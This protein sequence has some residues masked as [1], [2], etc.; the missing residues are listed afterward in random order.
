[1]AQPNFLVV[2][3]AL[4]TLGAA[5]SG[6]GMN[7]LR[8][9][10]LYE[11]DEPWYQRKRLLAGLALA[12]L[13][14]TGVDW[15]ALAF[16]PLSIVAPLG[17]VTI[18]V[19]ALLARAGVLVPRELIR[20]EQW[21]AIVVTIVGVVLV[22][23]YGPHNEPDLDTRHVLQHL[24]NPSF[25]A[26]QIAT[27]SYCCSFYLS[28]KLKFLPAR[29]ATLSAIAGV[30][31][32]MASGITQAIMKVMATIAAAYLQ[33]YDQEMLPF[34]YP[35]FWVCLGLLIGVA[36]VLFH[37]VTVCI[38]ATQV[39][40]ST[41]IYQSCILTFTLAA[42]QAFYREVSRVE[43]WDLCAF[44][45]GAMLV[46]VG[47]AVL[48]RHRK[49]ETTRLLDDR[50]APP[51]GRRGAN[52]QTPPAFNAANAANASTGGAAEIATVQVAVEVASVTG[53]E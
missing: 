16:T 5:I 38:G 21:A 48:V 47:L 23:V 1:M 37:L 34:K 25:V 15:I 17:S 51:G 45:V 19:S 4:A 50:D 46:L 3:I 10:K 41:P 27:L 32:G 33:S 14:N 44:L 30:G 6:L 2:G 52:V 22:D 35:A 11:S 36:I 9:S 39:S 20:K 42:A 12:G 53:R 24:Y 18:M 13:V 40:V 49:P 26:Y 31:A 28:M 43:G 7:L 29:G 8:A